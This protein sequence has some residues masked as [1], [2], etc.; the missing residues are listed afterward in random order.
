VVAVAN[1]GDNVPALIARPESVALPPAIDFDDVRIRTKAVIKNSNLFTMINFVMAT[2]TCNSLP[3]AHMFY[4]MD[5]VHLI[6]VLWNQWTLY[7]IIGLTKNYLAQVVGK[8][9]LSSS[10]PAKYPHTKH[11]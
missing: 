1:A 5:S 8:P 7:L 11:L 10:A 4:I 6:P 9:S 3:S 2:K